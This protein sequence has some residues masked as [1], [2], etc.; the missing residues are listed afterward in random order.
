MPVDLRELADMVAD[1]SGFLSFITALA[2][3]WKASQ[4]IEATEPSSPYGP[5]ALGWENA[6]VGTFLEAAADWGDASRG[7]LAFYQLPS[8]PWSRAAHILL[9]GKFY[10]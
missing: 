6:T 3:D 7:G 1:E 9:A 4:D 5:N 10:E 8:N 2:E